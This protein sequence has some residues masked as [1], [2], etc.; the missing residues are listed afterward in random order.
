MWAILR[1]QPLLVFQTSFFFLDKRG[2]GRRGERE[3]GGGKEALKHVFFFCGLHRVSFLEKRR[4][5]K[6]EKKKKKTLKHVFSLLPNKSNR[7]TFLLER[8]LSLHNQ[9][10]TIQWGNLGCRNPPCFRKRPMGRGGSGGKK[11]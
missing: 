8:R 10:G 11:K 4:R 7:A 3:G 2:G 5:E 1:P 9:N 6:E